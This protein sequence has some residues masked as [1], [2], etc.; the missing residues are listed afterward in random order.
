MSTLY[1]MKLAE[2]PF[3]LDCVSDEHHPAFDKYRTDDEPL[4]S[5]STDKELIELW[6]YGHIAACAA[7]GLEPDPHYDLHAEKTIVFSELCNK[8]LDHNVYT[9]HGSSLSLDGMG[10]IFT[11]HSGTGKSTHSS[12]WRQVFGDRCITIN[13]DKPLVRKVDGIFRVYGSPFSGHH[14]IDNN[15]SAPLKAIAQIVR[16]ETNH[17][18]RCSAE[19]AFPL[20]M[21][22]FFGWFSLADLAKVSGFAKGLISEVSFYKLYCNLEPEAARIA[23]TGMH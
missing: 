6:R 9:L 14:E 17:V 16:S 15:V 10:Y 5:I 2:I 13:D 19:E 1:R 20:L 23:Y 12:L 7:K 3:E 18:E 22:Q 8:L 21:T 11:A 4:F